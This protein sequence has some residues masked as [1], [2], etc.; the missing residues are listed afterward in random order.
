MQLARQVDIVDEA[1][2][3]GQEGHIL[4]PRQRS[5]D[6]VAAFHPRWINAGRR[7]AFHFVLR[8]IFG[9]HCA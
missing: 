5:A 8:P 9:Y 4:S 3:P 6:A 1:S 2:P 7:I